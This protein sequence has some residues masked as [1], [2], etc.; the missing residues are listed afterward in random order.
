MFD[1]FGSEAG[2]LKRQNLSKGVLTSSWS[3][4]SC[5]N[6]VETG[7]RG[8][9]V[10]SVCGGGGVHSDTS[11]FER[12]A[13]QTR[14]HLSYIKSQPEQLPIWEFPKIRGT[15]FGVLI[16]RVLLFGVLY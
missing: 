15:Y 11:N 1:G 10:I 6:N 8:V 5:R 13:N 4:F 14:L 7:F 2:K 12:C 3:R 16:I 9:Y